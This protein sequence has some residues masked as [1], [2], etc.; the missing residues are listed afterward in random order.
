MAETSDVAPN[1][2]YDYDD[3]ITQRTQAP[4]SSTYT[5]QYQFYGNGDFSYDRVNS[6]SQGSGGGSYTVQAGDTLQ[7][8]ALAVWG[9]SSLW[10]KLADTNGLSASASLVEGQVLTLPSGVTRLHN[11]ASTYTPY[12]ADQAIGN[13][14]PTAPKPK[15]ANKCGAFG[16]LLVAIAVAVTA[17]TAGAA[18][19]ALGPATGILSGLSA[20]A[21][22]SMG[23][24]G[25]AIGAGAAAAGSIV[26]QGVGVA[27]GIQQNFSWKN[28]ALAGIAGGVT[29]GLSGIGALSSQA[30]SGAEAFA[31]N[32]AR[33]VVSNV[34][35]QGIA[36]A[37]GLQ[38]KFDWAGVA[39]AGLVSGVSGAIKFGQPAG[40]PLARAAIGIGE[41]AISGAAGAIAGAAAHS[42]LDGTDFGDDVM[43]ALPDVLGQT[44]GGLIADGIGSI[45]APTRAANASVDRLRQSLF[46][47]GA[48]PDNQASLFSDARDAI[49]Y[50]A[51]HPDDA[52]AL[53]GANS[54]VRAI[55]DA[56]SDNPAVID[57]DQS[58]G[59]FNNASG[60]LPDQITVTGNRGY[61]AGSTIDGAGIWVGENV[62][63]IQNAAGQFISDHPGVGLAL[64]VANVGLTI[65]GG[66]ERFVGGLLLDHFKDGISGWF[67]NKLETHDWSAE[68]AGA[69]GV[70]FV[71]AG[72]LI[73][74]GTSIIKMG[75]FGGFKGSFSRNLV[76]EA[77]VSELAANGIKFTRNAL[78]ATGRD[79]R[80][81]V[82]FLEK[83]NASS[84]LQH[85]IETHGDDFGRAAISE[86]DV[87]SVVM[88]AVTEGKIVDYQ[89]RGRGRPIYEIN[90]GGRVQRIAVTTGS[91]G[92]IVGAN[93]AGGV[94]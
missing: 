14:S 72:S 30:M 94:P 55:L 40:S 5:F 60:S 89:G 64:S 24:V 83:G 67:S 90:L 19:A 31:V 26:S 41:N 15:K 29:A 57:F 36:L 87:P 51:A 4:P 75:I 56:N 25:V 21:D 78:V 9:D 38:D 69:G 79:A 37:T 28:V 70:G 52:D 17:V 50:A 54:S 8:I 93:P 7:S 46:A 71:A 18:A 66:P 88:R 20:L 6:F 91:N 33:G 48:I 12:D 16:Q 35:T 59:H 13:T 42:L 10:Y 73:L 34:A 27:T 58:I 3:S 85:I 92:Y 63:N 23:L 43:A 45:G 22:G 1:S 76:D 32:A 80:G 84:G 86:A 74:K 82:L 47:E 65:A 11:N 77:H 62:E 81:K 39:A 68:K 61:W 2:I 53:A 49:R 44:V